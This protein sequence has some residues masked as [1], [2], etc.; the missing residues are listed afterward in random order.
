DQLGKHIVESQLRRGFTV[1]RR[2]SGGDTDF[3]FGLVPT[4]EQPFKPF[5]VK[6]TAK[7]TLANERTE[8]HTGQ[9]DYVGAFEVKD[10]NQAIYLTATLDG[11]ANV[12]ML[13]VPKP[14]GDTML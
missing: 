10:S 14:V 13:V 6:R 4:G 12:D 8:V 9:Q 11:A 7:Q 1:I 2:N 5:E 3:A